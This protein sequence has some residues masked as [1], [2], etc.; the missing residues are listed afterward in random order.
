MVIQLNRRIVR[1]RAAKNNRQWQIHKINGNFTIWNSALIQWLSVVI[2]Q[3]VLNKCPI[4]A[5]ITLFAVGIG[6]D[7]NLAELSAIAT[8]PDVDHIFRTENFNALQNIVMKIS[9]QTCNGKS[10][11]IVFSK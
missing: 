2:F 7:I 1:D 4:I 8:D 3:I 6:P 5:G 11:I 9:N 10:F